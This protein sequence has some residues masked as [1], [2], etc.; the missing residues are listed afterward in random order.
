MINSLLPTKIAINGFGRIGRA[1]FKIALE[2]NDIE[3][4]AINDLTSPRILVH[5]LK[6]DTA[7]GIYDK[8]ILIE[9]DGKTLELTDN[10]NDKDFFVISGKENYLIIE[11]K[12]IKVL[13]EKDPSLLP[14]GKL[15]VDVVLE[16]TGRFTES[17]KAKAHL[18]AG[19]RKVIISAPSKSE[20]IQTVLLG[21]NH[22]K[23]EGGN[24][25]SNASCTTNCISP[26][27]SVMHSNFKILK[28]V[29][30]TVHAITAEQNNVDGPPPPMHPD[31]RRARAGG[32]NMLPTTTGAAKAT[33]NA[34]PD[35]KNKFDGIAIRVPV[36]VGSISDVTMLVEKKT[37]V[38]EVNNA[39]LKAKEHPF[40][41]N[42]LSTT[43][44]PIVSSDIIKTPY[45]AI[46]DLSMTKVVDGDLVKV[47][48]WYD[49]EWGYSNRLV[50]MIKIVSS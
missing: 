6:Y 40:Y 34:M 23:Y 46:V 4:V 50:E 9:E 12:R 16:C 3:V 38:E 20:D 36:I 25:V 49:N 41:K 31:M 39:F 47:L 1:S 44:E 17:E 43:Y 10:H 2:K 45:S 11:G 24:I 8:N 7:Y 21:V 28:S 30:T 18:T 13:S 35:L 42:V 33:T 27:V 37:T 22:D 26:I 5:L 15:D 14:W 48:A 19:A 29:M 32:F